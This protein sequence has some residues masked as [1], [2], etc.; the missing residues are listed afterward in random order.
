VVAALEA[1]MA[2]VASPRAPTVANVCTGQATSINTLVRQIAEL[3]GCTA[4]AIVQAPARAGD[5]R[6]SIGDPSLARRQLGLGPPTPLGIGLAR[7]LAS[8]A[9]G[10]ETG[11]A[12]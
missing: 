10:L 2:S 4:P 7:M 1:A 8:S 3:S 12:T 9:A 5:I 11:R 6:R